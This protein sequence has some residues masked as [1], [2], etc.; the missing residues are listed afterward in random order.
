MKSP[1]ELQHESQQLLVQFIRTELELGGTFVR[2]ATI[3]GDTGNAEPF[4]HAKASA[5][6]AAESVRLFMERVHN[7]QV[8]AEITR[9][10]GELEA[11]IAG[12]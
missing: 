10:V 8:R 12:L 11:E 2:S 3:A 9:R 5:I 7:A 6:R 1:E 4:A